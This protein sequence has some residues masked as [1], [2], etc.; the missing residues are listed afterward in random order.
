MTTKPKR[1]KPAMPKPVKMWG[2]YLPK[3]THPIVCRTKMDAWD[4]TSE[5]HGTVYRVLVTP[6]KP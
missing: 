1:A 4:W 2:A 3:R 6:V 5:F